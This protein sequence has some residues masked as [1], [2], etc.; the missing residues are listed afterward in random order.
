MICE[1]CGDECLVEI[2]CQGST[3]GAVHVFVSRLTKWELFKVSGSE[4][5]TFYQ[6][7]MY[8]FHKNVKV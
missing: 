4:T 6:G 1:V 3:S 7:V 2:I 8:Y 5:E